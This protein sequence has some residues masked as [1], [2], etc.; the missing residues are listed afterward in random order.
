MYSSF[1][2]DEGLWCFKQENM[3]EITSEARLQMAAQPP[4]CILEE[5]FLKPLATHKQSYCPLVI[6]AMEESKL[7]QVRTLNAHTRDCT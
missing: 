1:P 7:A 3:T 2:A 5:S 6:N 4:P